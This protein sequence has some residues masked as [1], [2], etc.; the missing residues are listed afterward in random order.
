MFKKDTNISPQKAG[1]VSKLTYNEFSPELQGL[2]Q[3]S[4]NSKALSLYLFTIQAIVDG[5]PVTATVTIN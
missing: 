1:I 3:I 5:E 2:R 4:R